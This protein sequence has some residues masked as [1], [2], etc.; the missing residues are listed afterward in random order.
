MIDLDPKHLDLV[1]EILKQHAP[2][3]PVLVFGSRVEGNAKKY[4]D[5]DLVLKGADKVPVKTLSSLREAFAESNLPFQ[6]DIIDWYRIS[7]EFREVILR[8]FLV[9]PGDKA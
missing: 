1:K 6:V 3:H 7:P 4:S 9:L 5:L 8:R 2:H